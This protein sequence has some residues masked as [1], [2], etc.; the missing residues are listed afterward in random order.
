ME[1]GFEV[2]IQAFWIKNRSLILLICAA[3]LL[4]IMAREGWQYFSAQREKGVQEEYAKLADR[5]DKLAAFALANPGHALAGIAYLRLADE[6]FSNADY[7]Q[8]ASGYQQAIGSLKNEALLGRA[9]LGM[10]M[11]QLNGGDKVTGKAALKALG[12]DQWLL[13]SARA[14]ATY[15]LAS[16]AAEAGKIDE[17]KKLVDEVG[18]IETSGTWSRRAALLLATAQIS[19]QPVETT[20]PTITFKPGGK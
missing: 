18:K 16:L 13:K 3:A 15:H 9:R 6:N 2:A 10:A 7:Q 14:E 12:T 4:A 17:M 11:S 20:T 5:T 1:P 19:G 8:A